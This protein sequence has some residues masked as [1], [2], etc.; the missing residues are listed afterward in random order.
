MLYMRMRSLVA[1]PSIVQ[2][3]TVIECVDFSEFFPSSHRFVNEYLK[4]NTRD[5]G[6]IYTARG[7]FSKLISTVLFWY[8]TNSTTNLSWKGGESTICGRKE[9]SDTAQ[10]FVSFPTFRRWKSYCSDMRIYWSVYGTKAVI[11]ESCDCKSLRIAKCLKSVNMNRLTKKKRYGCKTQW[12]WAL[13][14]SVLSGH[15]FYTF[16]C[17]SQ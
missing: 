12:K 1:V 8:S 11:Y 13:W 3:A 5:R 10:S 4:P 16:W 17:N 9:K 2:K 7:S 6:R 15:L 14:R